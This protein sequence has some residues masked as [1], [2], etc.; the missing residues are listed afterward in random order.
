MK[1]AN[2]GK[3]EFILV[4]TTTEKQKKKAIE[5]NLGGKKFLMFFVVRL[6]L[7]I[8]EIILSQW[9][10]HM[11]EQMLLFTLEHY[12]QFCFNFISSLAAHTTHSIT[13]LHATDKMCFTFMFSCF[14]STCFSFLGNI[15]KIC[16][17]SS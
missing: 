3:V 15:H 14:M 2:R 12:L 5:E 17:P 1:E 4:A 11:L 8:V 7:G 6:R 10:K 16:Q 13:P 9:M